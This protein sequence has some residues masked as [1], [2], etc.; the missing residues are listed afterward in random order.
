MMNYQDW[1]GPFTNS[2][3]I[4]LDNLSKNNSEKYVVKFT[5]KLPHNRRFRYTEFNYIYS[6]LSHALQKRYPI[7]Y[8]IVNLIPNSNDDHFIV[9][10]IRIKVL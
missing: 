3:L 8:E 7:G 10:T 5:L 2:F 9:V 6:E 1:Y 4:Q